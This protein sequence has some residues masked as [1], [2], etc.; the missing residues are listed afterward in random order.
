MNDPRLTAAERERL[1]AAFDLPQHLL[2][3]EIPEDCGM[4][5]LTLALASD[6]TRE[7]EV[8]RLDAEYRNLV[9]RLNRDGGQRQHEIGL[10]KA[11]EEGAET[12]LRYA[13]QNDA[14]RALL[15]EAAKTLHNLEGQ[16]V[17]ARD[18]FGIWPYGNSSTMATTLDEV[19]DLRAR[20]ETE[21]KG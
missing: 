5:A 7:V 19:R 17:Q 6:A 14:L 2:C 15:R 10:A 8:E 12:A 16:V 13:H 9:A 18:G 21:T 1:H 4:C 11:A 3:R 20:I